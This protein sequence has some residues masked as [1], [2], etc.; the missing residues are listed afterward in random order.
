MCVEYQSEFKKIKSPKG[1][2]NLF[3]TTKKQNKTK[4]KKKIT[5]F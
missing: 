2:N 5:D 4:V 3:S 1:K